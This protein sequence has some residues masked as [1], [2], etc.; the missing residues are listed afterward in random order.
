MRENKIFTMGAITE[1]IVNGILKRKNTKF[2]AINPMIKTAQNKKAAG[3][4]FRK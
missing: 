1:S 2:N 3:F 4:C